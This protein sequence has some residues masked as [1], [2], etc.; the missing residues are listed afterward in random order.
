MTISGSI[1]FGKDGFV[2]V[3][4]INLPKMGV[5][6]VAS[7]DFSTG[8]FPYS[9]AEVIATFEIFVLPINLAATSILYKVLLISN[10][11]SPSGFALTIYLDIDLV[12]TGVPTRIPVDKIIF[13]KFSESEFSTLI[14]SSSFATSKFSILFAEFID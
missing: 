4:G 13:S 3:P 5:A 2:N 1:Y 8:F 10:M 12:F 7:Q 9:R 11:Y 6:P 14:S